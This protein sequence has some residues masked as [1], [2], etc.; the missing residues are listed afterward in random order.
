MNRFMGIVRHAAA[1]CVLLQSAV[2]EETSTEDLGL[3]ALYMRE[4]VPQVE[5]EAP[6]RAH[7]AARSLTRGRAL[8]P[9]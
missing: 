3:G 6:R 4:G 8:H 9:R 2:L 1:L 7:V 5:H